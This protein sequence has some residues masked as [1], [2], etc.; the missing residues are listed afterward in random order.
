MHRA[1]QVRPD[2][3]DSHPVP[4]LIGGSPVNEASPGVVGA[5]IS[6]GLANRVSGHWGVVGGGH[7]NHAGDGTGSTVEAT[8]GGGREN[9]ASGHRSTVG[10]GHENTASGG[11]TTV[12]G[13]RQNTASGSVTM[14]GGSW[15]NTASDFQSTVGGGVGNSASG[16]RATVSGGGSNAASGSYAMAPGGHLNWALANYSFAAGRRA[17]IDAAHA[18]AFVWADSTDADFGS[19]AANEFAVRANG[20]VRFVVSGTEGLRVEAGTFASSPAPRVIGGS[21]VNG[22]SLE[23][24]GR[25]RTTTARSSGPT[26]TPSTSRHRRRTCSRCGLP[27]VLGSTRT[28]T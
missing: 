25:R 10:G 6:G 9:T 19:A 26:R 14:V 18:G 4:S 11:N 8:V 24:G 2:V 7:A 20:G 1:L 17:K 16:P 3:F 15:Q 13:G 5:T 12:G 28:P 23:A 27:A 21:T 22:R